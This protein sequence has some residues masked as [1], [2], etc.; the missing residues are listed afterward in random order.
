MEIRGATTTQIKTKIT[1]IINL[2]WKGLKQR[3]AS[4][5]FSNILFTLTSHLGLGLVL[6]DNTQFTFTISL[7]CYALLQA[8]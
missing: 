7:V 8:S 4:E 1:L 5:R 3:K 6:I 2:K